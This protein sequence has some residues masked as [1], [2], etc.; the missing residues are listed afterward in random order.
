MFRKAIIIVGVTVFTGVLLLAATLRLNGG[1]EIFSEVSTQSINSSVV[2]FA[3]LA[4]EAYFYAQ[5]LLQSYSS[6]YQEI[7]GKSSADHIGA[8]NTLKVRAR[9]EGE[10]DQSITIKAWLD[11]RSEPMLLHVPQGGVFLSGIKLVDLYGENAFRIDSDNEDANYL[12]VTRDWDAEVPL[13]IRRVIRSNTDLVR[14]H[15]ATRVASAATY[16]RLKKWAHTLVLVPLSA[17][18]MQPQPL[19]APGLKLPRWDEDLATTAQFIPYLN[20]M[21]RFLHPEGE[22]AEQLSRFERIGIVAGLPRA[23]T[24]YSGAIAAGIAQ[25]REELSE[26]D[27]DSGELVNLEELDRATLATIGQI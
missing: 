19:L 23:P 9:V 2:E 16:E 27:Q 5:P 1:T 7:A 11:L 12:I 6:M 24:R 10:S 21:L 18:T 17:Y 26:L 3:G 14:V 20:F 4:R 13:G 8:F 22:E 25:A 15:S